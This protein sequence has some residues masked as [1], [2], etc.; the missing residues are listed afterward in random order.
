MGTSDEYF[1]KAE[2]PARA[3]VKLGRSSWGSV[4]KAGMSSAGWSYFHVCKLECGHEQ[5]CRS[6]L[7][8]SRSREDFPAPKFLNCDTCLK[9]GVVAEPAPPADEPM[10]HLVFSAN[11][12]S[13]LDEDGEPAAAGEQGGHETSEPAGGDEFDEYYDHPPDP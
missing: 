11:P 5:I 10:E 7:Y 4:S 1:G 12:P 3:V 2:A 13:L 6:K 8:P 9:E